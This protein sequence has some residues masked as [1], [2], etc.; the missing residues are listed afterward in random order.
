MI[1]HRAALPRSVARQSEAKGQKVGGWDGRMGSDREPQM[2]PCVVSGLVWGG[3]GWVDGFR[4]WK[5]LSRSVLWMPFFWGGLEMIDGLSQR[6]VSVLEHKLSDE[7][8]G[9]RIFYFLYFF[10][11]P[12]I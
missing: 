4:V 10:L 3:G 5:G 6:A 7:W 11:P 1:P 2:R 9:S 8:A 12:R